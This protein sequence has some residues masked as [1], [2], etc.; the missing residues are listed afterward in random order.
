MKS[1]SCYL[2]LPFCLTFAVAGLL[3]MLVHAQDIRPDRSSVRLSNPSRPAS[4]KASL[5]S[6]GITVKGYDGKEVIVEARF[7]SP[8]ASGTNA[9]RLK[10]EEQNNVVTIGAGPSDRPI[11]FWSWTKPSSIA[12]ICIRSKNLRACSS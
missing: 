10:A 4:V 9:T 11:T 3:A 2:L 5:K 12:T 6:G 7:R 8:K 1:K